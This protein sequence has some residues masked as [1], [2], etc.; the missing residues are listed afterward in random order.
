MNL[1][2]EKRKIFIFIFF[3]FSPSPLFSFSAGGLSYVDKEKK[4]DMGVNF[5]LTRREL[6][7]KRDMF[8]FR[9]FPEVMIHI[10]NLGLKLAFCA[11]DYHEGGKDYPLGV[12]GG[13]GFHLSLLPQDSVAN[14]TLFTGFYYWRPSRL[15]LFEI[16]AGGM[17]VFKAGHSKVY[18][19]V[20]YSEFFK[21]KEPETLV[22][23]GVVIGIDYFLNPYF[24]LTAEMH[25]F[26]QDAVYMG[27]GYNF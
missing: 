1:K 20:K 4:L 9:L 11:G 2:S 18:A 7:G 22:P 10:K 24:F 17:L 23:V 5:G 26:D 6:D 12:G 14:I 21:G 27:A 8:S 25:N 16:S 13:G 15:N 3:L 19:G